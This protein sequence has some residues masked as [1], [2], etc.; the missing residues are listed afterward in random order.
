MGR[1][2]ARDELSLFEIGANCR[3]GR[4]VAWDEWQTCNCFQSPSLAEVNSFFTISSV[5]FFQLQ[6]F[7]FSFLSD[8]DA[9]AWCANVYYDVFAL[10][11][12]KNRWVRE[13]S[14]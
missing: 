12:D 3:L 2:A 10:H 13:I 8:N 11:R 1:T 7:R 6:L 14:V 5:L 9:E 4:I